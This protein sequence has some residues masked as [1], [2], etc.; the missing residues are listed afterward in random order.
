MLTRLHLSRLLFLSADG[1]GGN[2]PPVPPTPPTPPAP[3]SKT[4]AMEVFQNVV[5]AKNGLEAQ[6]RTLQ[7]Q[8]QGLTEKSATVDTLSQQVNEWKA[9][10]NE[11]QGRFATYTEFSGALGTTDAEVIDVFNAKYNALPEKDRPSRSD[12]VAGLKKKPEDAA[13]VL[14]P[15]LTGAAQ[16]TTPGQAAKP[17][18]K[19]PGTPAT[20]PGTPAQ[21]TP[22]QVEAVKQE[23][24]KTGNWTKW[25]EMSV[26]MGLRAADKK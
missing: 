19:V 6:V 21:F 12:W 26:A 25:K 10:A 14:R 15:W 9:K 4:V 11:A 8:L 5:Q 7:A 20:P 22:E 1:G 13:S 16:P 23:C 24:I 17:A 2:P 3:E 18:P